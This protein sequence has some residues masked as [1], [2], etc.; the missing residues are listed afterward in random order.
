MS[1]CVYASIEGGAIMLAT[2]DKPYWIEKVRKH[3]T[4]CTTIYVR[5]PC[6]DSPSPVTCLLSDT[7]VPR[8][9]KRHC[10]SPVDYKHLK[11]SLAAGGAPEFIIDESELP[12]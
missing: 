9:W 1:A 2:T 5:D 11:G 10:S 8:T 12:Y 7:K 6:V 3:C 4:P